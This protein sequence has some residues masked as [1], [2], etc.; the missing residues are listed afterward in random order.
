MTK[1][2]VLWQLVNSPMSFRQQPHWILGDP[3]GRRVADYRAAAEQCGMQRPHCVGWIDVMN[4]GIDALHQIPCH[5]RLRIDSFGQD[6]NVIASLIR[7]GGGSEFP[8]MGEILS[9]DHQHMG[10]CRVLRDLND[11]SVSR[12]D[13]ELDQQPSEIEAMF[14]KWATHHKMSP[15]R[16]ETTRLP[17]DPPACIKTLAAFVDDCGGRVFVKPQ[18]ASSASG[19]C[20]YRVSNHRQQLIA[21]I[22]I[23]RDSGHVRLFNSLRVRSY[24]SPR[25]IQDI[26]SVLAPQG[27]IAEAAV[28][29]ARVDG[30]RFDLRVVVIGGR[31]DHV[32]AR[33]SASPITNLHLGNA[34]AS[35]DCVQQAVGLGRLQ[36]CQHLALHA[37]SCFPGTLYCGVDILLPRSGAPLVCEVN[38]FGDFLPDLIAAGQTVYEAI[39]K[40]SHRNREVSV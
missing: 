10:I 36:A 21:P 4:E 7:H 19:V 32:I 26:F 14:D 22:E 5:S 13:V 40:S 20:C 27:M 24:T 31:A 17:T 39:L 8:Q 12:P 38:A 35:L 34:R 3:D 29:K 33:Q 23:V 16:P 6:Q 28:N 18:Y 25:D 2:G 30:D 9:L 1:N 15:H 11:W 37:A